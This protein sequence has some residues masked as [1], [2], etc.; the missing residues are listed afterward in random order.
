MANGILLVALIAEIA[1]AAYCI[2]TRS[3]QRRV[4]NWMR[5]GAL[6][7]FTVLALV[8]VIQWSMIWYGLALLLI[9]WAALGVRGLLRKQADAPFKPI[10]N[11][12]RAILTLL[13]IAVV[14]LPAF[15]LPQHRPI[16]VTGR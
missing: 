10:S 11:V 12:G 6:L 4:R 7:L 14:M 16:S 15:V 9:I 13:L 1:F 3:A 2:V 8:G 5:I